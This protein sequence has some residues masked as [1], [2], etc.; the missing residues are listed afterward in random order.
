[1]K[2]QLNPGVQAS[3]SPASAL[4]YLHI[5]KTAGTTLTA[6]LDA[7]YAHDEICPSQ[8]LPD[9]FALDRNR[10]GGYRLFRGH[11]W[12][13]L[14]RYVGQPLRYLTML[15]DP[16]QRTLSW[17]A[18]VRR[19]PNA[20]RHEQVVRERWSLLDFVSDPETR[21]DLVNTQTLSLAAD[22]DFERLAADPTGYGRRTI[23]AYAERGDDPAL[24]ETAK[25]RLQSMQFGIVERI[26]D[27]LALF[28]HTFGFDP[29]LPVPHLNASVDRLPEFG[30]A[31]DVRVAVESVTGLDRALY[32]WA[33]GAFAERFNA[34]ARSLVMEEARREGHAGL[35][36]RL[37]LQPSTFKRISV[38]LLEC[39][40][41]LPADTRV[42]LK[43]RV[44]ND[45]DELLSSRPPNPLHVSY[46]WVDAESG[47]V[48][49]YD[50]ERSVLPVALGAGGHL[51]IAVQV[52]TP[53]RS[54]R[55]TL[56]LRLVQEGVSWIEDGGLAQDVDVQRVAD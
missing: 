33:R 5:P 18:H 53:V 24:L 9:L 10:L 39:P 43:A 40:R 19:D 29:G 12:H 14:E 22:L 31:A 21:W 16:L 45:S 41:T 25:H 50:G 28:A 13:G 17:Y 52:R 42:V 20:Y 15:R 49:V 30:V 44:R 8:L 55:F 7:Q 27:S 51:T 38:M 23:R 48:V 26:E 34:M 36:W 1:M 46:H 4:Y 3:G 35:A 54:G 2:T 47:E 6:F 37:P 32:E 56:Q 11:L